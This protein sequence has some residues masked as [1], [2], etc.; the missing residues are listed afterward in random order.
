MRGV[1]ILDIAAPSE[2][3]TAILEPF[4]LIIG[5]IC[6]FCNKNKIPFFLINTRVQSMKTNA[7]RCVQTQTFFWKIMYTSIAPLG[8]AELKSVYFLKYLSTLAVVVPRTRKCVFVLF[9][10][11]SLKTI[12]FNLFVVLAHNNMCLPVNVAPRPQIPFPNPPI[13]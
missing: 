9:R 3:D 7:I 6:P 1:R 2:S 4:K 12:F 5:A 10:S 11:F 13:G 8:A